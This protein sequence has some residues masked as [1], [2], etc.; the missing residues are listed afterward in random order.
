LV[1]FEVTW[2]SSQT[3]VVGIWVGVFPVAVVP[4]WQLE[5]EP[6]ALLWSK[7]TF[8]QL[9]L[10]WQ[11]SQVLDDWIWVAFLPGAVEPL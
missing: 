3:L 8:V 9:E 6:V 1:Q 4:L 5:H 7:L 10:T 2:Q 11:S